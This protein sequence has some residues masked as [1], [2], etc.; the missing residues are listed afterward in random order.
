MQ[1]T[2]QAL[3]QQL[4]ATKQDT[5]QSRELIQH[6]EN[7]ARLKQE[8]ENETASSQAS[9][10][11]GE[12][13]SNSESESEVNDDRPRSSESS[14]GSYEEGE[15]VSGPDNEDNASVTSYNEQI[16]EYEI[17]ESVASDPEELDNVIISSTYTTNDD[18]QTTVDE[19]RRKRSSSHT[20]ERRSRSPDNVTINDVH[21]VA[22][23]SRSSQK[24]TRTYV[25]SA[26][27]TKSASKRRVSSDKQS[28]LT[29]QS[30]N[31]DSKIR[32]RRRSS[33]QKLRTDCRIVV[34]SHSDNAVVVNSS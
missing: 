9:S 23:T 34:S 32:K 16:D 25:S 12:D 26:C 27:T 15:Y 14:R 31:N 5:Q 29:S 2:I 21:I 20:V 30:H 13:Q 19:R 22:K 11:G 6:Y 3:Q 17:L 1:S 8:I 4:A 28:E 24:E 10:S 7:A 33:D 18:I